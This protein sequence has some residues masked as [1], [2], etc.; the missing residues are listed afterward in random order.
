[1]RWTIISFFVGSLSGS[2]SAW[3]LIFLKWAGKC[4]NENIWIISLLPLAGFLVALSYKYLGKE[5][6]KGNN[7]LIEEVQQPKKI[8]PFIMAPLVLVGTVITHLFGGSAGREGTA[9]QMGGSIADQLSRYVKFTQWERK[10]LIMCGISAGFA[11]VFGTPMAGAIFALEIIFIRKIKYDAII[12]VLMSAFIAN[13]VCDLWPITHTH[14]QIASVPSF[15]FQNVSLVILASVLFGLV[16][17]GFSVGM[18]LLSSVFKKYI[19][20]MLFRPVIGGV[21]VASLGYLLGY[22]Y[23]GLGVP[24]IVE[25]FTKQQGGEVFAIKLIL[26]VI[27]LSAGFKG[28]EVTPLFYIGATLGSALSLVLPLPISLLAGVGFVAVFS[29]AT[30]A[31]LACSIMG[32][33]L[34]GIEAGLF[35]FLACFVAFFVSGNTGIYS[36]QIIG[37]KKHPFL[38]SAVGNRLS[39]IMFSTK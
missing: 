11:S 23:L 31:P 15:N 13:Y 12:P 28:G 5:V 17:V 18:N 20:N 16:S 32:L 6:Q 19:K 26:T 25:S 39:E 10:V 8:I 14:Y 36:S 37:R 2:A 7:Q 9:V 35:I 3:F 33:E 38:K 29:G 30:N 1:V 34:F 4:R 21:I 24:T 22:K 27:T